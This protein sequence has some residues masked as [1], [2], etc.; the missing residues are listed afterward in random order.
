MYLPT[1]VPPPLL[2]T[3]AIEIGTYFVY[4][5]ISM[6]VADVIQPFF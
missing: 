3:E 6:A 4:T 2:R 1:Y 5:T